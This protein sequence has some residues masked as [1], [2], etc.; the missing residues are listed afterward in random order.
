MSVPVAL[1][2]D[3]S[4]AQFSLAWQ[5]AQGVPATSGWHDMEFKGETLG[6]KIDSLERQAITRSGMMSQPLDGK[7]NTGGDPSWDAPNPDEICYALANLIGKSAAPATVETGAYRHKMSRLESAV[8]FPSW[9]TA[10]A[11][12]N[13]NMA[14]RFH[15][16][17]VSSLEF[18]FQEKA[19]ISTVAKTVA[20]LGDYWDDPVKQGAGTGTAKPQVR[21]ASDLN[22]NASA[23]AANLWIKATS[24]ATGTVTIKTKIGNATAYGAGTQ[25][26]TRGVWTQLLD[27]AGVRIGDNATPVEIYYPTAGSIDAATPDEWKILW[28]RDVWAP[29]LADPTQVVSEV[30]SRVYLNGEEFEIT[31]GKLTIEKPAEAKFGFGRQDARR[32]RTRGSQ[33][34]KLD[35]NREYLDLRLRKLMERGTPFAFVLDLQSRAPIGTTGA[36]NF[37]IKFTGLNFKSVGSTT[38]SAT[39]KDKSDESITATASAST[40]GTYPADITVEVLNSI[41]DLAV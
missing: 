15:D 2:G 40:D 24:T 1:F 37:G 32:T 27:E 9:L 8:T 6:N 10:R 5:A 26:I 12:R 36:L 41:P 35:F 34:V 38:A 29:T 20:T 17:I 31:G 22:F 13:D 18:T 14:Q 39:S 33:A 3:P 16:L 19:L 28:T 23:T 30:Y 7:R 21:G 25:V 4:F 11:W